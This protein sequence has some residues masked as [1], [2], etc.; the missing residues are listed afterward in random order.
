M[1]LLD[2]AFGD[3][4][5]DDVVDD[6][7]VDDDVAFFLVLVI[8]IVVIVVV[9]E[10]NRFDHHLLINFLPSFYRMIIIYIYSLIII[11]IGIDSGEEE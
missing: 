6:D 9:V 10:L 1:V 2:V 5:D 4:V 11:V 3:V 7:V 8:V